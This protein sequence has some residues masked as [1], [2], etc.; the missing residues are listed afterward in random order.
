M[1]SDRSLHQPSWSVP[2]ELQRA[3]QNWL[4]RGRPQ[5]L[6][7]WLE[8][9]L[10]DSEQIPRFGNPSD[11]WEVLDL[12]LEWRDQGKAGWPQSLDDLTAALLKNALRFSRTDG[13]AVFEPEGGSVERAERVRRWVDRLDDPALRTIARWWFPSRGKPDRGVQGSSPPLPAISSER[14]VLAMLR[15][16]WLAQGDLLAVH[17]PSA[18]PATSIELRGRGSWLLG[19]DWSF[20]DPFGQATSPR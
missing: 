3:G 16:D 18:T 19:P 13:S 6:L 9:F 20:G 14:R 5:K 4:D 17:Q 2:P 10:N 7:R 1:S 12:L 8:R 15:P 11:W